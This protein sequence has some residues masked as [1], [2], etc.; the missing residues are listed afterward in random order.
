MLGHPLIRVV[1]AFFRVLLFD[2]SC[3]ESAVGSIRIIRAIR[4]FPP[5]PRTLVSA[6]RFRVLRRRWCRVRTLP[7]LSVAAAE[8]KQV[9]ILVPAAEDAV[10]DDFRGEDA[11]VDP[12]AAITQCKPGIGTVR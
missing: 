2:P 6:G 11:V 8:V 5:R 7:F 1:S 9:G 10:A 3:P 12:V 4:G